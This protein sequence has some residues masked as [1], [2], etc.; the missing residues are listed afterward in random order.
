MENDKLLGITLLPS[1]NGKGVSLA[2]SPAVS[3]ACL[4]RAARTLK[5]LPR[6]GSG[7]PESSSPVILCEICPLDTVRAMVLRGIL[8]TERS[9]CRIGELLVKWLEVPTVS[10]RTCTSVMGRISSRSNLHRTFP[11]RKFCLEF[12]YSANLRNANYYKTP[13]KTTP[14]I[15]IRRYLLSKYSALYISKIILLCRGQY[16]EYFV[17]RM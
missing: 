5:I 10:K 14:S 9:S 2:P 7:G 3:T 15:L 1:T 6:G 4:S 11:R 12:N 16:S 8:S 13:Y 17:I